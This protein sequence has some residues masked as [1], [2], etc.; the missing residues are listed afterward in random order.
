MIDLFR[1]ELVS[2]DDRDGGQKLRLRGPHGEELTDVLRIQNDGLSTHAAPGATML[3]LALGGQRDKVVALGLESEA[4]RPRNL[5]PGAKA[6]YGPDGQ[7]LLYED[8]A[9]KLSLTGELTIKAGPKIVIEAELIVLKG[10]VALGGEGGPPVDRTDNNP[11][12][13]VTAL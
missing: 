1:G 13:K 12:A 10:N 6:L 9:V 3:A 4:R 5:K 2:T 11:S 8:D 7:L